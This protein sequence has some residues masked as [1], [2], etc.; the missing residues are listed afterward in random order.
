MQHTTAYIS[1]A[2]CSALF[3]QGCTSTAPPPE[4]LEVQVEFISGTQQYSTSAGEAVEI[5]SQTQEQLEVS[6]TMLLPNPCYSVEA[7][8]MAYPDSLLLTI[9]ATP[10]QQMCTMAETLLPYQVTVHSTITEGQVLHVKH[11]FTGADHR[12]RTFQPGHGQ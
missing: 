3:F 4:P 8:G 1:L 11:T 9:E 5:A 6:G 10:A 7:S 2:L 12:A